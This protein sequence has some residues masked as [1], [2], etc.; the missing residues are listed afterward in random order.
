MSAVRTKAKL[1][2][3]TEKNKQMFKSR[4]GTKCS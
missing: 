4:M 2:S 1:L 3:G